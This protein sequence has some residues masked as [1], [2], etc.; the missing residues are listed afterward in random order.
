VLNALVHDDHADAALLFERIAAGH[1]EAWQLGAIIRF[2]AE[3]GQYR[4][5]YGMIEH[6]AMTML[7]L[8]PQR[9]VALI[10]DITEASRSTGRAS[11][12]RCTATQSAIWA[13]TPRACCLIQSGPSP[14]P[15]FA[16]TPT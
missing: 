6:D 11:H 15:T 7:T 12:W 13:Q 2:F 3:H 1:A 8:S 5:A 9:A 16:P 10:S 14:L 4:R